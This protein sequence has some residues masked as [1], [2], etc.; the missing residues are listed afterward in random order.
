LI[1]PLTPVMFNG[2][3]FAISSGEYR[4]PTDA[5]LT[6]SARARRSVPAVLYALDPATGQE[7]WMSGKTTTSFAR[8]GLS[9]AG[10]VS[11]VTCDDTLYA[12]GI[13]MQH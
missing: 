8:G 12:F 10:Q 1:S 3:I 11:V 9:A 6:A 7:L 2:V 5:S 4:A 13:P